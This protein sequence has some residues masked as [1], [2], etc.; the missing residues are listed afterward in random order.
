MTDSQGLS[1]LPQ[2]KISLHYSP[3]VP[4]L[5]VHEARSTAEEKKVS[6]THQVVKEDPALLATPTK[7][8]LRCITVL[9]QVVQKEACEALVLV[10]TKVAGLIELTRHEDVTKIL[11][12]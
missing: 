5:I 6:D 4:V 11:Y 3:Q 2:E 8:H 1:I 7:R 12:A 9:R 10:L